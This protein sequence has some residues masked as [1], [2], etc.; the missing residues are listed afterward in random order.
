M[1]LGSLSFVSS[2][3]ALALAGSVPLAPTAIV[4]GDVLHLGDVAD[5]S[6]LPMPMRDR[7]TKLALMNLPDNNDPVRLRGEDIAARARSLVPALAPWLAQMKGDIVVRRRSA[8]L[9]VPVALATRADGI[10]KDDPVQL[11]VSAGIYIIERRG[12]AMSDGRPG[13]K[14]FIRTE[15]GKAISALCCG[16]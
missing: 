6:Q 12:I 14:L 10:P 7:A 15:D 16:E 1:I 2:I 11:T 3:I 4:R 13:S 5:T 8:K 9:L